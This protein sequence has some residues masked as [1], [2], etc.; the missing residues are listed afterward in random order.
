[1][2]RVGVVGPKQFRNQLGATIRLWNFG[3]SPKRVGN[4]GPFFHLEVY[5]KRI[6]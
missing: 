6:F 4:L 1:M 3:S 5:Y 2:A